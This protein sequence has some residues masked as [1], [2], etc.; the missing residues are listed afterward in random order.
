[1]RRGH[2]GGLQS[3]SGSGVGDNGSGME[4]QWE[5]RGRELRVG[6]GL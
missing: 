2:S 3:S 6:A 5:L 4:C 1:M